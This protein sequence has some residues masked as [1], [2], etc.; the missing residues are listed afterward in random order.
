MFHTIFVYFNDALKLLSNEALFFLQ[1]I[2]ISLSLVGGLFMGRGTLEG[3]VALFAAMMNLFVLNEIELFG[4]TITPT[5]A[6]TLGLVFGLN[7]IHEFYGHAAA[8]STTS[9]CFY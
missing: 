1:V 7:L 5:D 2:I 8:K 3:L 4:F 9:I 6:F